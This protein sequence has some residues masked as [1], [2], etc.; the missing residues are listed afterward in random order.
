MVRERDDLSFV[1][2][3]SNLDEP[4]ILS[5]EFDLEP[6]DP[7]SVVR[8]MRRIWIIKK[9]NQPYGHQLSGCIFKNPTPD[10]SAG[11]LIDQAGLKGTRYAGAEVSDRHAN[12]II[13]HPDAKAADILQL[14]DRI[15]QRRLAAIRLRVRT[16]DPGLVKSDKIVNRLAGLRFEDLPSP[17]IAKAVRVV[18]R[19]T[20][21]SLGVRQPPPSGS[22]WSLMISEGTTP[23]PVRQAR[24]DVPVREH[25]ELPRIGRGDRRPETIT[26]DPVVP[27]QAVEVEWPKPSRKRGYRRI[28]LGLT[29]AIALLALGWLALRSGLAWLTRQSP[30]Q[31]PFQSIQ[32][33]P[34]APDW[35]RGGAEA[36]LEDVRR[37]AGETE[38]LPILELTT[39]R[40]KLAFL[41]SAWVESVDGVSYPPLGLRVELQYREP[42]A[43]VQVDGGKE[44]LVDASATILPREEFDEKHGLVMVVRGKGLTD[45][46]DPHPGATWK[47]KPGV[48]EISQGNGRI[49][50]AA[51]LASF[52]ADKLRADGLS[53]L[54]LSRSARSIPWLP[55]AEKGC[56]CFMMGRPGFNGVKPPARRARGAWP[57]RRNGR[58]VR[59]WSE[60]KQD[61]CRNRDHYWEFSKKGLVHKGSPGPCRDGPATTRPLR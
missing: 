53:P 9:E 54:R 57:P 20:A 45:P 41:Q 25:R 6:E 30:Y 36:F 46:I 15:R 38:S 44:Y 58:S 14:I 24:G 34:A 17:P 55:T 5:A 56:F 12:F 39:N 31:I 2:R 32:L 11:A 50:A 43:R 40:V 7:E 49:P 10:V 16:P 33:V 37:R 1:N 42:V 29:A 26:A 51:K 23:T 35:V 59:H 21:E 61:R 27:T 48:I 18:P 28:I 47:P 19:P 8:R 22:G 60:P 3:D 13:A 4:V 52:L